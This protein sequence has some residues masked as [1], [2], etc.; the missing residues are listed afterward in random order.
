MR[1][2]VR[3]GLFVLLGGVLLVGWI[4]SGSVAEAGP[5]TVSIVPTSTRPR[6]P[7]LPSATASPSAP[8]PINPTTRGANIVLW[9]ELGSTEGMEQEWHRLWT[10]VQWQ[11]ACGEW[12]DVEGWRGTPDGFSNGMAWK[13]WWVSSQHLGQGPFRWLIYPQE[14]APAIVSESFFLPSRTDEML[15]VEVLLPGQ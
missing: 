8:T 6:A 9:V 1:H 3:V 5:E 7:S 2:I 14:G 15:Q 11:D 10:V 4:L 13:G 12:H